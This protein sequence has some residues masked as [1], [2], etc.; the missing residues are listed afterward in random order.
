MENNELLL[1]L[2][3]RREDGGNVGMT[4]TIKADLKA[5]MQF[6]MDATYTQER[7]W[8]WKNW[9]AGRFPYGAACDERYRQLTVQ[10]LL[11]NNGHGDAL[12]QALS[13]ISRV[14]PQDE[15][16]VLLTELLKQ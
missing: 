12:D 16:G 4:P 7:K 8:N 10:H 15:T 5:R 6:S 11:A 3:N 13:N 14:Q 1:H 9:T 2:T